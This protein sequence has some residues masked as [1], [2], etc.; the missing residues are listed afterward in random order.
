MLFKATAVL[1]TFCKVN[2]IVGLGNY[3]SQT[4]IDTAL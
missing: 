4:I 3:R 2:N 1:L